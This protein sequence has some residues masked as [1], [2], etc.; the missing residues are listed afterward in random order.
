MSATSTL[1]KKRK[2]KK[3]VSLFHASIAWFILAFIRLAS[4][5]IFTTKG[6]KER[7]YE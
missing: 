5:P 1:K 7:I 4:N 3:G 2:K 6:T